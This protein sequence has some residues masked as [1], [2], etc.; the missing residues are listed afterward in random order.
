ME[1]QKYWN[2]TYATKR[3]QIWLKPMLLQ[4]K[5]TSFKNSTVKTISIRRGD[6]TTNIGAL[7]TRFLKRDTRIKLK[8]KIDSTNSLTSWV[9]IFMYLAKTYLLYQIQAST[10][11]KGG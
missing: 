7:C 6:F 1:E 2:G 10:M 8:W 11:N 3:F 5:S 4:T 9:K